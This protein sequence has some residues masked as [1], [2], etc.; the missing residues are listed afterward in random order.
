MDGK[1]LYFGGSD[2]L[3]VTPIPQESNLLAANAIGAMAA[4][5]VT[6]RA[7]RIGIDTP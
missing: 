2:R 1:T 3:V 6:T 5:P 4:G 7:W